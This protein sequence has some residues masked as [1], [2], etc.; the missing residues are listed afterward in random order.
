MTEAVD[1]Y[2]E[3]LELDFVYKKLKKDFF[4]LY[5]EAFSLHNYE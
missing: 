5:I 2:K 1:Y 4:A 3:I